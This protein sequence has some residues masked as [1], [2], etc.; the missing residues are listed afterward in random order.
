L[1]HGAHAAPKILPEFVAILR[2]IRKEPPDLLEF[3]PHL[4][5]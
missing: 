5:V 3:L 4:F 2:E 1:G